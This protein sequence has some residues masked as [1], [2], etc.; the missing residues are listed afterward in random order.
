MVEERIE[1]DGDA[2]IHIE[3]RVPGKLSGHDCARVDFAADDSY[4]N[5]LLV[6]QDANFG[7]LTGWLTFARL[8][9]R[10][11]PN[12]CRGLPVRFVQPPV[13]ADPPGRSPRGGHR[14]IGT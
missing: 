7:I 2:I 12:R 10:K 5:R 1:N 14:R 4:V 3:V 11:W 6:E 8:A 13:D 9:L